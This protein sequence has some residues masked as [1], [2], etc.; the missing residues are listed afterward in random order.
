[1][2]PV[3]GIAAQTR[4]RRKLIVMSF[5]I[6]DGHEEQSIFIMELD[7]IFITRIDFARGAPAT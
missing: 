6:G 7:S 2:V 4:D 5:A 1:M 3:T